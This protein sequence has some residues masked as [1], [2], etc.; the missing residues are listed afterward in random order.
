MFNSHGY[1][2]ITAPIKPARLVAPFFS[3][4]NCVHTHSE[5]ANGRAFIP[6]TETGMVPVCGVL[7][8]ESSLITLMSVGF[9]PY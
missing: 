9:L 8:N 4:V 1:S 7:N 3:A 6:V 2:I 5:Y